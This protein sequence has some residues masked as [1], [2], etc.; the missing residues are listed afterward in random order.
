MAQMHLSVTV[1]TATCGSATDQYRDKH[2]QRLFN[3]TFA[4]QLYEMGAEFTLSV[5]FE[6]FIALKSG[7]SQATA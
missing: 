6:R 4:E 3:E 7:Y 1:C 2:R 5:S